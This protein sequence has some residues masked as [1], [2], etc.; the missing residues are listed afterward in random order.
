MRSEARREYSRSA[1]VLPFGGFTVRPPNFSG[2]VLPDGPPA[3]AL[4]HR[5]CSRQEVLCVILER[6]TPS[7][8]PGLA[9]PSPLCCN[10]R[11]NTR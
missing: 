7:R 6:Y 4:D 5:S 2:F 11:A 9:A 8:Q 1:V 3:A 10:Y